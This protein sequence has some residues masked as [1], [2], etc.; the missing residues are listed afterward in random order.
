[1]TEVVNLVPLTLTLFTLKVN[2]FI[3]KDNNLRKNRWETGHQ[4]APHAWGC[5]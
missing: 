4:S 5:F 3:G 1:V 2:F